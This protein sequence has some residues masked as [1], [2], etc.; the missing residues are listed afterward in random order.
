MASPRSTGTRD[1]RS[2]RP[3]PERVYAA[4]SGALPFSSGVSGLSVPRELRRSSS[5]ARSSLLGRD[6]EGEPLAGRGFVARGL[7]EGRFR[8]GITSGRGESALVMG[9]A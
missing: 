2:R 1:E 7:A 8:S 5:A 6:D 3:P 4:L 9:K